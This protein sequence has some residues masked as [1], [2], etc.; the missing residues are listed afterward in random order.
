[1]HTFKLSATLLLATLVGCSTLNMLTTQRQYET[2]VSFNNSSCELI[3]TGAIDNKL[4]SLFQ[5]TLQT[6]SNLSKCKEVVVVLSSTGGNVYPAFNLG[7]MIRAKNFSTKIAD[8]SVCVSACGVVFI[9]GVKRYMAS[10]SPSTKIGFH[11]MINIESGN[12]KCLNITDSTD[13]GATY[14]AYVKKMLPEKAA[15]FYTD[16]VSNVHCRSVRYFNAETLKVSEIVT[17]T[18]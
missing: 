10:A 18:Y 9:S 5:Q 4:V 16:N 14:R 7:N 3:L 6:D 11:Q 13:I 2:K 15:I 1:M 17:D 12:D 8:N